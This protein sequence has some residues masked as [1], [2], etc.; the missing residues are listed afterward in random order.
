VPNQPVLKELT[1]HIAPGERL[2]LAGTTGAGKSTLVSLVP[3][4]FDPW[5]GCVLVDGHDV[6]KVTLQS[7][8]RQVAMV[9]QEPFLFPITIAENIAYGRPHASFADIQ[10]AARSARAE[11][12]IRRLPN[13]YATIIGERGATLSVGER[14]RLSIA[15]AVLKNAPIL[16]LDEPASA[17]DVDTEAELL[18]ALEAVTK[19][20]T[21]LIIAHRLSTICSSD[22][23]AVLSQGTIVEIGSYG[24]LLAR[25]GAFAELHRERFDVKS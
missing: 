6:R 4:F 1:L 16:I 9:L 19:G 25:G 14:Q 3:R 2:A 24:E 12:F 18:E 17:L 22:R 5:S 15:R 10:A 20:R 23:I 8:R 7:L 13:G 11:D 21:T